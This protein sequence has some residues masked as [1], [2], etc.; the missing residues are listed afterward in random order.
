MVYRFR[1][2]LK[3]WT[4]YAGVAAAALGYSLPLIVP[5]DAHWVQFW[6]GAQMLVGAAM[7]FT[8]QTAGTLAVENDSWSLLKAFAANVPPQYSAVMQP[9]IAELAAHMA[10]A[11][12]AGAPPA[13]RP[14]AQVPPRRV[15][16]QP[17]RT[18]EVLRPP[19]VPVSAASVADTPIP[20]AQSVNPT[21]APKTVWPGPVKPMVADPTAALNR[22]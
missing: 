6:Q 10:R 20:L 19:V 16:A 9:L 15:M 8:P 1:D 22:G 21:S 14:D 12:T 18:P 11:E 7:I 17:V 13:I 4:S 3:E 2:R 5:A